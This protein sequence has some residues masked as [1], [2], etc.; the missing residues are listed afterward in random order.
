M[1]QGLGRRD[2]LKASVAALAA[3]QFSPLMVLSK[4]CRFDGEDHSA[5]RDDQS[6]YDQRC[7]DS[8]FDSLQAVLRPGERP[9]RVSNR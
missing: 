9:E 5:S 6:G 2:F 3:T 8:V 1:S 7:D 4:C